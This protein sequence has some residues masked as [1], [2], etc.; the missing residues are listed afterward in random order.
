MKWFQIRPNNVHACKPIHVFYSLSYIRQF[1]R[2]TNTGTRWTSGWRRMGP[3]S[4]SSIGGFASKKDL[5]PRLRKLGSIL[6][7]LSRT[8]PMN[9]CVNI[10]WASL[11]AG[12]DRSTHR[13][14][15][16]QAS[17]KWYVDPYRSQKYC[18]GTG[19]YEWH[20]ESISSNT[21]QLFSG[22]YL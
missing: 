14:S 7:G 22:P 11:F 4:E 17:S 13:I 15:F 12:L 3:E 2:H 6:S 8:S 10:Y 18:N 19:K 1:R 9:L 16:V 20:H 5:L 21:Q